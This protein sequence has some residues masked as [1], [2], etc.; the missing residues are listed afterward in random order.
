MTMLDAVT[1]FYTITIIWNLQAVELTVRLRY[2]TA[3]NMFQYIVE[4]NVLQSQKSWNYSYPY[5]DNV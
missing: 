5:G 2:T 3:K 1:F 4:Y